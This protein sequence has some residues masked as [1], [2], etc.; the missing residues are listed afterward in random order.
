M[1][2]QIE[3]NKIRVKK[4]KENNSRKIFNH[5]M[6]EHSSIEE[7]M[8][9]PNLFKYQCRSLGLTNPGD[10]IQLH[11]D[12][13]KDRNY[14]TAHYDRIG[15]SYTKNVVWNDDLETLRKFPDYEL[16][17]YFFGNK[18]NQVRP[19]QKWFEIARS[20]NSKND[21]IRV[22]KELSVDVPETFCFNGREELKDFDGFDFPI[23]LKISTSSSGRG[24][25]KCQNANDL[26][27][28]FSL[29]KPGIS[30]QIQKEIDA[31][32]FI[33]VQYAIEKGKCERVLISEQVLDGFK[34]IGNRFPTPYNDAWELTD[35]IAMKM[36]DEGMK[37]YFAFDLAVTNEG[38]YIAIECNP[39]VNAATYPTIIAK[40]LGIKSWTVKNY[41]TK[42]RNFIDLHLEDMEY[43]PSIGSGII[44]VNWGCIDDGKLGLLIAGT[45]EEQNRIENKLKQRI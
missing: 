13:K 39:R 15:L 27:E 3:T 41:E 10:V 8:S 33:N 32:T 45:I 4:M 42:I 21:F 26:E 12:L 31:K 11:P 7:L 19:D 35:P 25:I 6:T 37:G 40:R 38:K 22:C 16:S 9:V 14:I 44:I 34:H 5:G 43:D 20:M 17:I 18:V 24:V 30:F 28:A 1:I 2:Y 36:R 23:Y 29:I